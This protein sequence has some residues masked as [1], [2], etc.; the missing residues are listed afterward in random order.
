MAFCSNCGAKLEDGAAFCM[1]CGAKV[2]ESLIQNIQTQEQKLLEKPHKESV[3]PNSF[4]KEKMSFV[5]GVLHCFKHYFDF[6]GMAS[7]REF[8][9]YTIFSGVLIAGILRNLFLL[10]TWSPD[11]VKSCF[12]FPSDAD[13]IYFAVT[14]ILFAIVVF[15]F[16]PWVS[17][18]IRRCNAK[19]TERATKN[20]LS[21]LLFLAENIL[22][23][24]LLFYPQLFDIG[25]YWWIFT[26]EG[27]QYLVI[28][29][30]SVILAL[31]GGK[32][33]C[34]EK[35]FLRIFGYILSILSII[36]LVFLSVLWTELDPEIFF[37]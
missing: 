3:Q 35:R 12:S 17:L 15:L 27:W 31:C 23:F 9:F 25:G 14:C 29:F 26:G 10:L 34:S 19:K 7:E 8:C 21:S 36:E 11:W 5:N 1:E 16:I 32:L 37:L 13:I 18:L 28:F 2:D 24:R 6:R 20:L 33:G 30:T 22:W 4:E